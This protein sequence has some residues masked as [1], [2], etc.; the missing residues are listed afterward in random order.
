MIGGFT[1][2]DF[3]SDEGP[4][5]PAILSYEA[6]QQWFGGDWSAIGRV[7]PGRF[8]DGIRVAGILPRNFVP[9]W[10]YHVDVVEPLVVADPDD[11]NPWLRVVVRLP[12]DLTGEAAAGRLSQ[13][14]RALAASWPVD[15]QYPYRSSPVDRIWL[16]PIRTVL[17]QGTRAS[18]WL[19][20]AAAMS[21]VVLGCLNVAGL[22]AARVQD[23]WHDLVVRRALGARAWDLVRL[24]A[25]ED[26]I[27]V[28]V[29]TAAGVLGARLLLQGTLHLMPAPLEFLKLPAVDLR[30]LAFT[31]LA[32][33]ACIAIITA[34][35]ARAL[36]KTG[37]QPSLADAPTTS[38]RGRWRSWTIVT[39]QVA[40]ALVMTVGG[41]LVAGS[42]VQVW[43]ENPGFDLSHTYR[44][45]AM[46][47]ASSAGATEQLVDDL[48]QLPGVLGAGGVGSKVIDNGL[49]VG[50]SFIPPAG[51]GFGNGNRTVSDVTMTAGY[52][53]AAGLRPIEGRL[54][55]TAEFR[56]GAPVLV[57]SELVARQYWPHGGGLGAVLELNATSALP[58]KR[59][60][61]VG[62]V[63][64]VR[65]L[66]LDR[67]PNGT[68]Y[69][70]QAAARNG[71]FQNIVIRLAAGSPTT[72]QAAAAW[73]RRRCPT[74]LMFGAPESLASLFSDSVLARR[75]HGWVF[76]SF[77]AASL[78]IVGVGILGLVAMTSS[79]R[80]KEIGI[81][82]ALGATPSGVTRQMLRE[83]AAAVAAGLATGG[84]VAAWAVQFVRSYLYKLQLYDIRVWA[85]AVAALLAMALL[86]AIIPSRRASR[87]DPVRALRVD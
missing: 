36:L 4:A 71:G 62:V 82:L 78:V 44:I 70:P 66:S 3:K 73:I 49:M 24:L 47:G 63:P 55:T 56:T 35:A 48:R 59:F 25:V 34:V 79:R 87:V 52:F 60:T 75:F 67:D 21:L 11:H 14:G 15:Q 19:V 5:V 53:E 58:A 6:W 18:A 43:T 2:D 42:L 20:L 83:Q 17:T 45:P 23:R 27:V 74:C 38:R 31:G 69:Y 22:A 85:A 33:A 28:L 80:T 54:P 26:S 72:P 61:V 12:D 51:T 76:A 29:G 16:E 84:L 39:G 9:P 86:G 1:P 7:L 64:D 65:Y 13:V 68:I 81:R 41:A 40:L 46:G 32:A 10:G 37:L 50:S 8:G 57:V 30:V 77:A